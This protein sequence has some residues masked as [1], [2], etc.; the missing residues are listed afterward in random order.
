MEEFFH[1]PSLSPKHD[2]GINRSV[3]PARL[4]GLLLL[5]QLLLG[6]LRA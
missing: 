6:L 5:E 3:D 1:S 4:L 2:G